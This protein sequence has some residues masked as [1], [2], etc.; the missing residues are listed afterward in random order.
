MRASLRGR[1]WIEL[2]LAALFAISAIL[3]L[4]VPDWI[5]VFFHIEPDQGSGAVERGVTIALLVLTVVFALA[6]RLEFRN[7][8]LRSS[9][10]PPG[11]ADR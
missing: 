4:L 6:A 9:S 1:F 11:P 2:G 10:P 7:A 8:S 5:E 3:T